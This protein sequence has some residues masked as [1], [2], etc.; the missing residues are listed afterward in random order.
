MTKCAPMQATDPTIDR[1]SDQGRR[2]GAYDIKNGAAASPCRHAM[3]LMLPVA[4]E[5]L[6][7]IRVLRCNAR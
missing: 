6:M 7:L 5:I 1:P 2:R 4:L 3:T